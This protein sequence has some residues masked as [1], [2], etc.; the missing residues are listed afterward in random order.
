LSDSDIATS[1]AISKIA[2]ADNSEAVVL[3]ANVGNNS[4]ASMAWDIYYIED[5]DTSP[6]QT[7][8][9]TLVGQVYADNPGA[10]AIQ[11]SQM[12]FA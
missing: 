8:A 1:A 3:C 10:T 5:T 11:I 12:T 7:W 2:V 9:V 4:T 6:S